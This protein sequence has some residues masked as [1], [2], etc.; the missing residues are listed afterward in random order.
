MS[1]ISNT[2]NIFRRRRVPFHLVERKT[3]CKRGRF[4]EY[5][6]INQNHDH[7]PESAVWVKVETHNIQF[8]LLL[9]ISANSWIKTVV[10]GRVLSNVNNGWRLWVAALG[11]G[12][13]SGRHHHKVR[14]TS[15]TSSKGPQTAGHHF[16]HEK[17]LISLQTGAA[18]HH[19]TERHVTV[20]FARGVRHCLRGARCRANSKIKGER[21]V[22]AVAAWECSA[23]MT[24][25]HY[26]TNCTV[27]HTTGL[28]T[29]PKKTKCSKGSV[30]AIFFLLLPRLSHKFAKVA[31]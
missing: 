25:K 11:P 24:G 19:S 29:T 28:N 3:F 15:P 22:C 20:F 10:A 21:G 7:S 17:I 9:N 31:H 12:Y 23:S 5:V 4:W 1:S 14:P 30:L 16:L 27:G 6:L 18:G 8:H 26:H 13:H 2:Q